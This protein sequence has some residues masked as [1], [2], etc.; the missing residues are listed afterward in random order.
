[1]FPFL[2][3]SGQK[4]KA[5][6]TSNGTQLRLGGIYDPKDPDD[7]INYKFLTK[8]VQENGFDSNKSY[9]LNGIWTFRKSVFIENFNNSINTSMIGE[10]IEIYDSTQSTRVTLGGSFLNLSDE[11]SGIS[12]IYLNTNSI[13]LS[14]NKNIYFNTEANSLMKYNSFS[15][16]FDIQNEV[17][18]KFINSGNTAMFNIGITNPSSPTNG[19]FWFDGTNFKARIGGV[20]KTFT[21]V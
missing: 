7:A 9:T 19:D 1:M 20:T 16:S 3:S 21:L 14:D 11:S 17:P 5:V 10:L 15:N 18:V 13:Q 12:G 8:Y 2:K 4:G 6:I